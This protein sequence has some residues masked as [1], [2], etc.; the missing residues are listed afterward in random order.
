[1]FTLSR[2][3]N[4]FI[5]GT[6]KGHLRVT[7][8]NGLRPTYHHGDLRAALLLAAEQELGETGIEGFSL[9]SVAKRAGVSHAAPAHHFHDVRGLL[10][11]LAAEGFRRFYASQRKAMAEWADDPA[12]QLAASGIGY[13][14]FAVASPALFRLI[15]SSYRPDFEDHELEAESRQSYEMLVRQVKAI[16]GRED[17]DERRLMR[18]IS[19]TWSVAHGLADLLSSGRLKTL[20]GLDPAEREA[21]IFTIIRSASLSA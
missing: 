20:A 12:S 5:S 17:W 8:A 21:E 18:A 9:R 11:A 14:R 1:M 19:S 16:P 7:A 6:S 10:T 15:F 4:R 2:L 3:Q 13:V